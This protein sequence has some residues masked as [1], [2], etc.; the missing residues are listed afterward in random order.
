MTF[1]KLRED[2][3]S[4]IWYDNRNVFA[5]LVD[6]PLT[7][8]HSQLVVKAAKLK[9]EEFWFTTAAPH[10]ASCMKVFRTRLPNRNRSS[11]RSLARYTETS[12]KYCKTLVLKV[13]ADETRG[14]YKLHLVPYFASHLYAT[15]QLYQVLNGTGDSGAGGLLHWIGQ[16]ERLV[17][18]DMRYGREDKAVKT[19]IASFN[20]VQLALKLAG[21]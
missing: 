19:R 11:W 18:Y 9:T 13:S 2:V 15:N 7:F 8:G 12:G 21:N 5:F 4:R 17:D 20:L 16:R 14:I 10:V 6:A 1:D 3:R